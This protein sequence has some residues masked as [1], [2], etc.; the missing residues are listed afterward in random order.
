MH[1]FEETMYQEK[2]VHFC[3]N[4]QVTLAYTIY[5]IFKPTRIFDS[6][7]GWGDRLI[8]AIAAKIPYTGVDPSNCLSKKYK[9][10]IKTLSSNPNDYQVISLG[11]EDIIR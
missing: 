2:M 7:A 5:K 11:I 1:R 10:I 4:F 9:N 6:S 3:N 8:A